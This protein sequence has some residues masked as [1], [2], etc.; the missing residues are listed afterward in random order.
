MRY[1]T[2]L[3]DERRS[4]VPARADPVLCARFCLVFIYLMRMS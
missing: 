2:A 3:S 1:E 4:K